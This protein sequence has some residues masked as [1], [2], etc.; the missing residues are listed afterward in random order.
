MLRPRELAALRASEQQQHFV[1]IP[2]QLSAGKK[3]QHGVPFY[4]DN[5]N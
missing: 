2:S 3:L 5:H 4:A 1:A